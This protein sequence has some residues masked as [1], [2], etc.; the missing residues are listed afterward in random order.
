[1]VLRTWTAVTRSPVEA[2]QYSQHLETTV[3]PHLHTIPGHLGAY[4]LQRH[5]PPGTRAP[6]PGSAVGIMVI[7]VWESTEALQA[8]AG[9][10]IGLAVIDPAVRD[11][12]VNVDE[13]VTHFEVLLD[14]TRDL[15]HS[16][17]SAPPVMPRTM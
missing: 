10:D 8:F 15:D 9:D 13:R 12:F 5:P 2:E 14:S 3:F 1:M 7:T 16:P 17:P 4:L 6:R 11:L